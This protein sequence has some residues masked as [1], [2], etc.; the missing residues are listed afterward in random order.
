MAAA[1]PSRGRRVA[2]AW[3]LKGM[4]GGAC[5]IGTSG[6]R[7][8]GGELQEVGPRSVNHK[9]VRP[10]ESGTSQ[11]VKKPQQSDPKRRCPPGGV[12]AAVSTRR[13]PR[14]GVHAAVS[15]RRCPRGGVHRS[16]PWYCPPGGHK[17]PLAGG[18]IGCRDISA[19]RLGS[20]D[21]TGAQSPDLP[22]GRADSTAVS[23]IASAP[24]PTCPPGGH[25]AT[26]SDPLADSARVAGKTDRPEPRL[27]T[28]HEIGRASCRER[29]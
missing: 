27:A 25:C 8:G 19:R 3:P 2:V 5:P 12:H 22:A 4:T 17:R 26:S 20:R 23:D 7:E 16:P 1:W 6:R 28:S 29:V 14:G 9:V 21:R 10:R 13:C 11:T 15:T 18:I 24:C